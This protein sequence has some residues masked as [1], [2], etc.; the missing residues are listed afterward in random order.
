V[1]MLQ[2]WFGPGCLWAAGKLQMVFVAVRQEQR[3]IY[4]KSDASIV[5][6]F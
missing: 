1:R 3:L 4:A 2:F 5:K 6:G